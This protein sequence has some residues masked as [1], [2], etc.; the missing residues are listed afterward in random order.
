MVD[1]S[2]FSNLFKIWNKIGPFNMDLFSHRL[3]LQKKVF[4]LKELGFDL[5]YS[6][7]KYIRGPYSNALATDGYK[8][9]T[10]ENI[11]KEEN[12]HDEVVDKVIKIGENHEEDPYWFELVATIVYYVKE[13]NKNKREVK[14]IILEEKP[15]LSD[16]KVF[17]EAYGK[18]VSLKVI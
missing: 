5:G 9:R 15:Y 4:L 10:M 1:D 13:E 16:E 17:E 7:S 18:L 3:I 6:F 11:S 12:Y 8:I 2:R 14:E